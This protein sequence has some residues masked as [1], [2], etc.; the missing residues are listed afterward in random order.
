[1]ELHRRIRTSRM[2]HHFADD[3]HAGKWCLAGKTMGN[4]PFVFSALHSSSGRAYG[5][6]SMKDAQVVLWAIRRREQQHTGFA[7]EREGWFGGCGVPGMQ[8]VWESRAWRMA[9]SADGWI[10]CDTNNGALRVECPVWRCSDCCGACRI[11]RYNAALRRA[12]SPSTS[13]LQP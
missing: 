5:V 13:G 9:D 3:D 2:R 12:S 11:R 7:W 1:M 10:W 6:S 4:S 8:G